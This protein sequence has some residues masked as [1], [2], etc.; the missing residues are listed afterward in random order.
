MLNEELI[1][2]VNSGRAW[3]LVG[4]GASCMAGAPS[5]DALLAEV[6]QK[7]LTTSPGARY[8][9]SLFAKLARK[10]IP[11]A[12]SYLT[13]VFGRPL[14][15]DEIARICAALRNPGPFHLE[16]AGWQFAGY[17][18]V[19]Y[20]SLLEN[21]LGDVDRAG[22]TTVGNSAFENRNISK[23]VDHVVWHPHGV[24]AY[25][26]KNSRLVVSQ[27]D[28]DEFYASGSSTLN[29]LDSLV[30]MKR[31]VVFGFGFRDPDL[32]RLLERLHRVTTPDKPAFAFL[33]KCKLTERERFRS[34][35]NVEI[36]HYT[37]NGSD[38][39]PLLGLLK[40]YRAFLITRDVS[41]TVPTITHPEYDQQVTSLLT[42]NRLISAGVEVSDNARECLLSAQLLRCFAGGTR[43][44][45]AQLT[46]Q[47]SG[48]GPQTLAF[49]PK[50]VKRLVERGLLVPVADEFELAP[51]GI[52]VTNEASSHAR[53]LHDQFIQQ[54]R[55]RCKTAIPSTPPLDRER[56]TL[57]AA[58][59]FEDIGR[60]CGLALGQHLTRG[61]LHHM[62][63]RQAALLNALHLYI[64]QCKDGDEASWL[65]KI[66]LQVLG[67]P[68]TE[69][70]VYLGYLSQAYFGRH[71]L[72]AD[73]NVA[74]F[75][76]QHLQRTV[77]L[78][79]ASFIIRLLA[80]SGNGHEL[81]RNLF[82]RL[83][84]MGCPLTTT[85]LLLDEVAEHARYAWKILRKFGPRSRQILDEARRGKARANVFL[86]SYLVAPGYGPDAHVQR[87]FD[88]VANAGGGAPDSLSL[89]A[90]VQSIGIK[91]V[92][93]AKW[94]G[95]TDSHS[96]Q[97]EYQVEEIAKRRRKN[98]TYRRP[99]QVLAEA[100]VVVIVGGLRNS[101]LQL[102]GEVYAD[103]FFLTHSRVLDGL[104]GM[105][106]W[107]CVWPAS[108]LDW[109]L[110]IKDITRADAAGLFEQ[111]LF[112]LSQAGVVILP[113]GAIIKAFSGV[114][115][116]SKQKVAEYLSE[117]RELVR[118]RYATD[119]DLAFK[120]VDPL[121]WPQVEH[122]LKEDIVDILEARLERE[123]AAKNRLEEQLKKMKVN[124]EELQLLRFRK[125]ARRQLAK[126]RA[127]RDASQPK[128]K[129]S[130]KGRKKR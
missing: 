35:Y 57:L 53:L 90:F 83:K 59:Y 122:E 116:A 27:Y 37:P 41:Y 15:E 5:W 99:L 125:K 25:P 23:D 96:R 73:F 79:D 114:T 118:E 45:E 17:L 32:L 121:A 29:A 103:A 105:P 69:E 127:R 8:D 64:K 12:F 20:D 13:D 16:I 124:E 11:Q 18:T 74:Q 78:L 71:L 72:N 106:A 26:Q 43:L 102:N 34:Q 126:K 92:D 31:I 85:D 98:L 108:L 61:D 93:F 110:S 4:S 19:N 6:K 47:F 117:R 1:D 55:Q 100:E 66:V 81:A 58:T 104:P 49:V 88:T 97:K 54:I 89:S 87:Y 44:T 67:S 10:G 63:A 28:Y 119:P 22:W 65:V 68:S 14:I 3:A 80:P 123:T 77:F 95:Y 48:C 39:S 2:I 101:D 112:E 84:E 60:N 94:E 129:K 113:R 70:E 42:H 91:V 120:D 9:D 33:P 107:L 75:E 62:H 36:I 76:R 109:F 86:E 128:K 46:T 130:K 115:D 30:R 7:C 51:Q 50:V 56:I 38:H 82:K 24:S 40:V 21:A 52:D 111:I